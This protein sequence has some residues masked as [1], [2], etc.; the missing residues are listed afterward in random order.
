MLEGE[1]NSLQYDL[2]SEEQIAILRSIMK[3]VDGKISTKSVEWMNIPGKTGWNNLFGDY[4]GEV[5]DV[6]TFLG[7]TCNEQSQ[8]S[9]LDISSDWSM[10]RPSISLVNS[11]LNKLPKL[12]S[13]RLDGVLVMNGLPLDLTTFSSLKSLQ[14]KS[15]GLTGNLP[16]FLSIPKYLEILDLRKNYLEGTVPT[17]EWKHS[18]SSK[19]PYL[20]QLL[21]S[22]NFLS[23][24]I[25]DLSGLGMLRT[26]NL[27]YNNLVSTIPKEISRLYYLKKLI[28]N[29]NNLTGTMDQKMKGMKHLQYL[30]LSNNYLS[31]TIPKNMTD[32]KR[33]Q[34]LSIHDN[35]FYG[36]LP[37]NFGRFSKL[38]E[39]WIMRNQLSGTIPVS[40]AQNTNLIIFFIEGNSFSGVVPKA[41]C[42]KDI[43]GYVYEETNYTRIGEKTPEDYSE[44]LSNQCQHIACPTGYASENG[45]GIYPCIQCDLPEDAPFIATATCANMTELEVLRKFANST[46]SMLWKEDIITG[47]TYCQWQGIQCIKGSIV[48]IDLPYLDLTGTIPRELGY[49]K[50]L[51][52]LNLAKNGFYGNVPVELH[53]LQD[54]T[55]LDVTDNAISFIPPLLCSKPGL[56]G[57]TV[58]L[59]GGKCEHIV[60]NTMQSNAYGREVYKSTTGPE[61]DGGQYM[62]IKCESCK[63]ATYLGSSECSQIRK[64][65]HHSNNGEK[66]LSFG[67]TST[68]VI[69]CTLLLSLAFF[70]SGVYAIFL[71]QKRRIKI[72]KS[73]I[74]YVKPHTLAEDASTVPEDMGQSEPTYQSEK[75]YPP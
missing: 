73:S 25:P 48:S 72:E 29:D 71:K 38:A 33:L 59:N 14:M 69:Y 55:H 23:G 6:C 66:S 62:L 65:K 17:I 57:Y 19:A 68:A 44:F 67:N 1:Q 75:R 31:G 52:S 36:T 74:K 54:L 40:L 45:V 20:R 61:K 22:E 60:C 18:R 53:L 58:N 26:L 2:S 47:K 41:L 3:G 12:E 30:D 46:G 4:S 11:T 51:K 13:L 21:L 37:E 27:G 16:D 70:F 42:N 34:Y 56:N 32:L 64:D 50:K 8:I 63:T 43:N 39:L 28:L 9:H 15:C 5:H 7:I 49:L 10:P 24:T 35:N